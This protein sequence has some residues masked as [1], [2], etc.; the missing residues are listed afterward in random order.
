L[1]GVSLKTLGRPAIN[2]HIRIGRMLGRVTRHHDTGLGVVFLGD[3]SRAEEIDSDLS[4]EHE[5][6]NDACESPELNQ[7]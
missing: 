4:G 6:Q 1:T 3:A 7:A 2:E 5:A